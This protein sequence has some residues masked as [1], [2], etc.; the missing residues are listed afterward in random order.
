MEREE[1]KSIV[2]NVLLAADQ[3]INSSELCKIFLP[4]LDELCNQTCAYDRTTMNVSR[5][6]S[7][8]FYRE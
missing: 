5:N 6:N 7:H 2:E 1:L 3:P 8:N 4:G